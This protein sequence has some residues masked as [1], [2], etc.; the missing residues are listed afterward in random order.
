MITA[1]TEAVISEYRSLF[2]SDVPLAGTREAGN[3]TY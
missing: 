3:R 1:A 2:I